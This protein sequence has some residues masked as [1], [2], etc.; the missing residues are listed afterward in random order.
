MGFFGS[1]TALPVSAPAGS[2]A[3]GDDSRPA[4]SAAPA[5]QP[6]VLAALSTPRALL[7]LVLG[8]LAVYAGVS[9][10]GGDGGA[11]SKGASDAASTRGGAK[12]GKAPPPPKAPKSPSKTP[13]PKPSPSPTSSPDSA[14]TCEPGEDKGGRTILHLLSTDSPE[15]ITMGNVGG[16]TTENTI[17]AYNVMD[18]VSKDPIYSH[19]RTVVMYRPR[20]PFTSP[21]GSGVGHEVNQATYDTLARAGLFSNAVPGQKCAATK[22]PVFLY[23]DTADDA[24]AGVWLAESAPSLVE[25]W[26]KLSKSE[27]SLTLLLKA[28]ATHKTAMLQLMGIPADRVA[29]VNKGGIPC[30]KG[31]KV[32]ISPMGQVSLPGWSQSWFITPHFTSLI[33]AA[34]KAAGLPVCPAQP[35]GLASGVGL[36]MVPRTE[37]ERLEGKG[38]VSA[39]EEAMTAHVT[40]LGGKVVK[41]PESL[42]LEDSGS[43]MKDFVEALGT[44]RV[45]LVPSTSAVGFYAGLARGATVIVEGG[46]GKDGAK[47]L[48]VPGIKTQMGVVKGFNLVELLGDDKGKGED[49]EAAKAKI[50]E[51]VDGKEKAKM[52]KCTPPKLAE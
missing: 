32:H 42:A 35:P 25:R 5:P 47:A 26:T 49:V 33:N 39:Y 3:A 2:A 23:I 31:N 30:D 22:P 1:S 50:Q 28:P 19:G 14:C 11:A 44:A 46:K 40:G 10:L 6:G 24:D 48:A 20:G 38:K 34:R 43:E 52:P 16:L 37:A 9:A 7:V 21:I 8:A 4:G 27:D 36:V 45:L 51:V 29:Y 13:K 17:L 15:G 18:I 12:E 41:F